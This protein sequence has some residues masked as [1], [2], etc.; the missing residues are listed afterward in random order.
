M[1]VKAPSIV[2]EAYSIAALKAGQPW[3]SAGAL[4]TSF[5]ALAWAAARNHWIPSSLQLAF[6][7]L[8]LFGVAVGV[9]GVMR[10]FR[11]KKANPLSQFDQG[12]QA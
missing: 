1:N 6:P 9:Y 2:K 10:I 11:W 12:A 4:L 8:E 7:V 5:S 3:F